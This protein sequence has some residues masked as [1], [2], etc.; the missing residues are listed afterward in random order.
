MSLILDGL[1]I[2]MEE[3]VNASLC[4]HSNEAISSQE[5]E[6]TNIT[7]TGSQNPKMLKSTAMPNDGP[8]LA[9]QKSSTSGA[10]AA[11][12]KHFNEVA[13]SIALSS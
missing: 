3:L 11:S 4:L 9:R 8:V 6:R 10:S 2:D 12:A 13:M 5:T 1:M 7:N